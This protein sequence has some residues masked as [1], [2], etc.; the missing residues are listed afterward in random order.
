MTPPQKPA[1]PKRFICFDG[2]AK[3]GNT[4]RA[5]VLVSANNET[6]AREDDHSF[7]GIDRI[8]YEYDYDPKTREATNERPRR[9]L[10]MD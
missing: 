3:N 9:D 10:A 1:A 8:W 6:E 7:R 2:R 5:S 4:E